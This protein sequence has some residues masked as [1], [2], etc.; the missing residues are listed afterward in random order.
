MLV[1]LVST[2]SPRA[3]ARGCVAGVTAIF[4]LRESKAAENRREKE[5]RRAQLR[6]SVRFLLK[7]SLRSPPRRG[8]AQ[9]VLSSD[10]SLAVSWGG[11][12]CGFCV[13]PKTCRGGSLPE[14]TAASKT[15]EDRGAQTYGKTGT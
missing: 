3:E 15:P 5:V 6:V 13:G 1:Q 8:S 2:V 7:S 10:A 11:H 4:L 12:L 14:S 9:S